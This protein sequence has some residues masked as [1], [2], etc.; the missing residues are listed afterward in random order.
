M[1]EGNVMP[2]EMALGY[3]E[4]KVPP[5]DSIKSF[6]GDRSAIPKKLTPSDFINSFKSS[7]RDIFLFHCT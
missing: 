5:C 2:M 6:T 7:F 3:F 4:T 1:E